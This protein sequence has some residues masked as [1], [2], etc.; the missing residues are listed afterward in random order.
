M[1]PAKGNQT[2]EE[3]GAIA[4]SGLYVATDVSAG[5]VLCAYTG[6]SY[7]TRDAMRL[8]D[9]SYLMRL[10]AQVYVDARTRLDVAA[11]Y[12]NDCRHPLLYN[13]RFDKRPEEEQA[14][15]VATRDIHAG[16][17]LFVD[18][19]WKYWLALKGKRLPPRIA[20]KLLALCEKQ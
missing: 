7:P 12:I 9:H 11:R 20:M 15:V 14:L 5:T 19:G 3:L 18:Y 6:V 1:G 17:E 8:D 13:V 2:L 10:G 4:G 16:E